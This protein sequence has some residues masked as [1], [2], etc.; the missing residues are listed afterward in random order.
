[1]YRAQGNPWIKS[2]GNAATKNV[3]PR[4]PRTTRYRADGARRKRKFLCRTFHL[5]LLRR[6]RCVSSFACVSTVLSISTPVSVMCSYVVPLNFKVATGQC[7]LQGGDCET[8]RETREAR[9]VNYFG[10]GGATHRPT[11]TARTNER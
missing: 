2:F 10:Q 9:Q 1:M 4:L 3:A 11:A 7:S 5:F 8:R 6:R